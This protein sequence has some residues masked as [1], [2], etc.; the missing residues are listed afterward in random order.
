MTT[1]LDMTFYVH[2]ADGTDELA[3]EIQLQ[4][5]NFGFSAII[6]SMVLHPKILSADLSTIVQ[7]SSTFG[8]I[9]TAQMTALFQQILTISLDPINSAINSFTLTIPDKIYGLFGLS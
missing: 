8:T 2:K 4:D 1:T 9:D 6:D 3:C 5:T 7:V